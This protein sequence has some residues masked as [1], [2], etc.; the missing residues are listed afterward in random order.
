MPSDRSAASTPPGGSPTGDVMS[1]TITDPPANETVGTQFTVQGKYYCPQTPTPTIT[2]SRTGPNNSSIDA[3]L[4]GDPTANIN[5][6][7]VRTGQTTPI[8]ERAVGKLS[9]TSS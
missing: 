6:V 9:I 1:I 2:C 4:T 7:I 3:G 5:V 8:C